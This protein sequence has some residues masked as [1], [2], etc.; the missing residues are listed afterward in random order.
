MPC[1]RL[2]IS[3]KALIESDV[4]FSS[5]LNRLHL[6]G[7]LLFLQAGASTV[8]GEIQTTI[9]EIAEAEDSRL[10]AFQDRPDM[11]LI[12][13]ILSHISHPLFLRLLR[14]YAY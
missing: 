11:T 10:K 12:Q 4:A 8:E 3:L 2:G 6:I 7:Q 9:K 1:Y 13:V 14:V 5:A